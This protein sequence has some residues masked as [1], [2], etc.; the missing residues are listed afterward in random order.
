LIY[1]S[2]EFTDFFT[3]KDELPYIYTPNQ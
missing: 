2:G 1:N 3:E